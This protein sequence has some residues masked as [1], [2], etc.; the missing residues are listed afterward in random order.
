[1]IIPTKPIKAAIIPPGTPSG[2]LNFFFSS[3]I[4][5]FID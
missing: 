4:F 1:M 5:T 3:I 2:H